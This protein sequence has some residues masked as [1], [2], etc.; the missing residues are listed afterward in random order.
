AG[1]SLDA[2]GDML[3]HS[4]VDTTR[5]YA[6]IVRRLEENPARFLA[7]L[8]WGK[9]GDQGGTPAGTSFR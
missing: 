2:I 3:G 7:A 6:K 5:V 4:S 1:A 9:D 8:L